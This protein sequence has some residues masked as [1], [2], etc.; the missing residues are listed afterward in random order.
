MYLYQPM[1]APASMAIFGV[2]SGIRLALYLSSCSS[3]ILKLGMETTV[4]LMP[5]AFS[6][7]AALTMTETSEPVAMRMMSLPLTSSS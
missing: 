2:S 6:S 4:A 3:K 1:V 7:S 5:A